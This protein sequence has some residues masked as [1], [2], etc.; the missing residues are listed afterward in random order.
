MLL[1]ER[2]D[3]DILATKHISYDEKY[4]RKIDRS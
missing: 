1:F 3:S 2:L 4:N